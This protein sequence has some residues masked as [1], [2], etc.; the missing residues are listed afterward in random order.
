LHLTRWS[1]LDEHRNLRASRHPLIRD[2]R[3]VCNAYLQAQIA[4]F[5]LIVQESLEQATIGCLY[6]T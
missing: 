4:P 5:D 1:V 2:L 3:C 6:L